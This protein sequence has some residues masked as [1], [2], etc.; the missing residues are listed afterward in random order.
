MALPVLTALAVFSF[1]DDLAYQASA[2][3][4]MALGLG[5]VSASPL[6][7]GDRRQWIARGLQ[8][9]ALAIGVGLLGAPAEL[10]LLPVVAVGSAV[11]VAVRVAIR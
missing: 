8:L 7:Y 4:V 6:D 9:I 5:L 10:W 3:V 2:A 11:Q 1:T